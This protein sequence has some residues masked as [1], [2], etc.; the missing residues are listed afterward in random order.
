[1]SN[2]IEIAKLEER[3]SAMAEDV[4]EIKMAIKAIAETLRRIE[5]L[6]ERQITQSEAIKRAHKRSDE[7]EER[8]R[9]IELH[10]A[11]TVW[12]ERILSAIVL[13]VI[14]LWIKGGL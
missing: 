9:S 13:T 11:K 12:I 2:E 5:T 7:H 6:E 14:G 3:T 1:M 4:A 8:I 10:N